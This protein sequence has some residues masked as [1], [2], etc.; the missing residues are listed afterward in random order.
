MWGITSLSRVTKWVA[1]RSPLQTVQKQVNTGDEKADPTPLEES[2]RFIIA[3][4]PD[5][6]GML[7]GVFVHPL[8]GKDIKRMCFRN[9]TTKKDLMTLVKS[10]Q[11]TFSSPI[12]QLPTAMVTGYGCASPRP[13][14]PNTSSTFFNDGGP[15]SVKARGLVATNSTCH[16]VGHSSALFLPMDIR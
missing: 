15:M 8:I 11:S 1:T 3:N 4:V 6:L 16:D 5:I 7:S 2:L 10:I 12:P 13:T 9:S 14:I